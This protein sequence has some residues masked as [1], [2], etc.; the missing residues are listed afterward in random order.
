MEEKSAEQYLKQ[1]HSPEDLR[2][3]PRDVLAEVCHELREYI[4]DAVSC[5]PG[6]F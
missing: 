1:I 5:N 4:I 2:E 6:H 3:L